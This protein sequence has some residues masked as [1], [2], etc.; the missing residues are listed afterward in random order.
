MVMM[1]AALVALQGLR[2][3]VEADAAVALLLVQREVLDGALLVPPAP[4]AFSNSVLVIWPLPSASIS[5]NRSFSASDRLVGVVLVEAVPVEAVAWL[6]ASSSALMVC[7]EICGV[8]APDPPLVLL[9]V[10]VAVE[11]SNSPVV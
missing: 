3:L 8:P 4:S 1:A 6:C 10:D 7:G 2:H 5:E 11:R 9:D